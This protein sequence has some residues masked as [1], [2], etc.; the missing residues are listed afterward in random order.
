MDNFVGVPPQSCLW[1]DGAFAPYFYPFSTVFLKTLKITKKMGLEDM[2]KPSLLQRQK[3]RDK[4]LHEEVIEVGRGRGG[5]KFKVYREEG[6]KTFY[7]K[8]F[9]EA[10]P[11]NISITPLGSSTFFDDKLG[12]LKRFLMSH[13]GQNWDIVFSKLNNVLDGRSLQGLHIIG[14]IWDFV[15]RN[16]N[17]K[18]IKRRQKSLKKNFLSL[19]EVMKRCSAWLNLRKIVRSNQHV[20]SK[21]SHRPSHI[22]ACH[23]PIQ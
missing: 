5:K 7:A 8:N 22:L 13:V 17:K 18:R 1:L 9:V 4:R 2:V 12:C 23:R 15:E 19:R 16:E 11:P 3:R 21:A 20:I 14:H 10:F 6:Y